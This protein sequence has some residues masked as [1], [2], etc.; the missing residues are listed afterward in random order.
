[1]EWNITKIEE[2]SFH[3][4]MNFFCYEIVLFVFYLIIYKTEE[5]TIPFHS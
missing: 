1:M 2:K 4:F 3:S 5:M